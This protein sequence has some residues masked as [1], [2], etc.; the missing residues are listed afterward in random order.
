NDHPPP[1]SPP[2][3]LPPTPQLPPPRTPI[4]PPPPPPP[5]HPDESRCPYRTSL[6][7][8]TIPRV[9]PREAGCRHP[10]GTERTGTPRA[11]LPHLTRAGRAVAII[12][13]RPG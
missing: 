10:V 1:G 8:G 7:P 13:R 6:S 4:A 9:S 3:P 5:R 11:T 12:S 2:L